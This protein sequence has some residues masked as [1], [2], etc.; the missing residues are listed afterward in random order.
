ML[1]EMLS[2]A[3]SGI[4]FVGILDAM[5]QAFMLRETN[6]KDVCV[7]LAK[8]GEIENTWGTGGRKPTDHT[9]IK[10]A[11]NQASNW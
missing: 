11:S 2:T 7:E 4:V 9:M 10:L 6:I 1:L 5:L 3:P 8:K